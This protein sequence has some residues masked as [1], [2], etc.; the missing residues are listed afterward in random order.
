MDKKLFKKIKGFLLSPSKAF[1]AEEK[2]KL[3]DTFKYALVGLV[4]MGLLSGLIAAFTGGAIAFVSVLFMAII[5][6][7]V[8]ILIGGLWLHLWAYLFGAKKGVAQTIKIVAYANTPGYYLGWIP[9]INI[10]AGIWTI[11][12]EVIGLTKLQKLS[13]G[14][15]VGAVLIA[16]IIPLVIIV[17]VILWVLAVAAPFLE[18]GFP[19]GMF[20]GF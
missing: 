10:V 7:T 6:G 14:R 20:G 9:L 1:K 8:A 13:T 15:A 19:T 16:I 11:V 3:G 2:T 18:T 4:V 5:G 17:G 12:L